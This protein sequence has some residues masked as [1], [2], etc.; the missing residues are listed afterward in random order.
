VCHL[1]LRPGRREKLNVRRPLAGE[2]VGR[3]ESGLPDFGQ[4]AVLVTVQFERPGSRSTHQQFDDAEAAVEGD[5][6]AGAFAGTDDLNQK[7]GRPAPMRAA[8]DRL[9]VM[10]EYG[11]VGF[12][13]FP[14]SL[15]PIAEVTPGKT[16]PSLGRR[17]T[18]LRIESNSPTRS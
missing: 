2:N 16:R 5:F 15:C 12:A 10:Q 3:G 14:S 7:I 9:P 13:K 1:D 17:I 4:L 18:S 8:V 11:D 6:L